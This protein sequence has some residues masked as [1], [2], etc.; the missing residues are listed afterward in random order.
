MA[1]PNT[2]GARS[3]APSTAATLYGVTQKDGLA[4]IYAAI[5]IYATIA[6]PEWAGVF[7]TESIVG[8]QHRSVFLHAHR[9]PELAMFGAPAKVVANTHEHAS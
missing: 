9:G 2:V 7:G 8:A 5:A 4:A 6:I 1:A 3:I